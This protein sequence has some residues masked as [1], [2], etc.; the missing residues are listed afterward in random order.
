MLPLAGKGY[1]GRVRCTVGRAG[2]AGKCRPSGMGAVASGGLAGRVCMDR[3]CIPSFVYDRSGV[4]ESAQ[5]AE[6]G[7]VDAG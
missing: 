4:D 3:A 5:G 7:Y 2:R 6:M 1:I